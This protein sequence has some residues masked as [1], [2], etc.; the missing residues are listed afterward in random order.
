MIHRAE[1]GPKATP[2]EPTGMK[3]AHQKHDPPT[4]TNKVTKMDQI[5]TEKGPKWNLK[6]TKYFECDKYYK[7]YKHYKYYQ[8]NKYNRYYKKN[9]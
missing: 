5:G 8:H 7:Y 4:I 9:K 3:K 1:G 2:R 6:M